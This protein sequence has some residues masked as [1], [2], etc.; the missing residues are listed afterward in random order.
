MSTLIKL[1]EIITTEKR[2][3]FKSEVIKN[4]KVMTVILYTFK[5]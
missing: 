1:F 2:L 5:E 4:I 3:R